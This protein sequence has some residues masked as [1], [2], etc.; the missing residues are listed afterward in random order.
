MDKTKGSSEQKRWP[1]N[2]LLMRNPENTG[3]LIQLFILIAVCTMVFFSY[4]FMGPFL[5]MHFTLDKRDLGLLAAAAT[6]GN[7][8]FSFAAGALSDKMEFRK[9]MYIGAGLT[10]FAL[11]IM[12]FST[13]YYMILGLTFL[14]GV[15][16]SIIIH[17]TNKQIANVFPR[18]RLAFAIG[19]KQSGGP[20]GVAIGSILLPL[21]ILHTNWSWAYWIMLLLVFATSLLV[22][23]H[24]K[25]NDKNETIVAD[26]KG[27]HKNLGGSALAIATTILIS[28]SLAIG[29]VIIVTFTVPIYREQMG[30]PLITATTLLGLLQLAGALSRPCIGLVADSFLNKQK[31][32]LGFLGLSNVTMLAVL[33]LSKGNPGLPLLALLSILLGASSMGW[34]GPVHSRMVGLMGARRAGKASGLVATFNLLAMTMVAPLFGSLYEKTGGFQFPLCFFAVIALVATLL[35]M[36]SP[37]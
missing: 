30:V 31:Q 37:D 27:N 1:K 26:N 24:A 16:Y 10:C 13:S 33:G 17:L 12:P 8:I 19:L 23:S 3:L 34:F 9:V 32:V 4:S 25:K 22:G 15:A 2:S 35:F 28:T 36:F 11:F 7:L 29:Q 21:L 5:E 14:L 6:S 20:F 18:R